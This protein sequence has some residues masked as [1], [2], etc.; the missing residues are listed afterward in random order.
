MTTRKVEVTVDSNKCLGYGICLGLPQVFDIPSG[1][2]VAVVNAKYFD[3]E[4][5]AE[6]EDAAKNCPAGA[7][8][9]TVREVSEL[10]AGH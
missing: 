3:E 7:I 9:F 8:Q 4:L 10:E 5:L 1:Q 6:I 2:S